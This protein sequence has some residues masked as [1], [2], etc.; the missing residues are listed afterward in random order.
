VFPLISA[1]LTLLLSPSTL[2]NGIRLVELPPGADTVEIV[3]GYTTGG[4]TGFASTPAAKALMLDAYA[5]GATIDFLNEIDRTA[6]RIRTAKWT[7]PMLTDRLASLF[8]EVPKGTEASDPSSRD[9]R[10]KVEDEIR[11]A[12]VGPRAP[13]V[14]YATDEAFVLISSPAP[15]SL[16]DALSAIPKRASANRAEEAIDRLPAERTFRFKSDIPEGAVIFASPVPSVYYKQWYLMLLLDR[17]IHHVVRLPLKT[18]LPLTVRPY[19]YRVE[20]PVPSGQLPEPAE[21]N[22]LQE[23]Q[24]LQFTAANARDLAAARQEALAYLDSNPVREWF[25]SQDIVS[26]REEGLQWL[27]SMSSD[28][29]RLAARD[30]LIMNRVLVTWS[31]RPK[32]IAVSSEPLTAV[33]PVGEAQARQRAASINDRPGRSQSAPIEKRTELPNERVPISF[34]AHNDRTFSTSL[35]E[36]LTSGVSIV[37]STANAVFVSG[38]PFTRFDHELIAEDL[39]PFQQYR[40]DRILVLSTASSMD[41]ARR[42]WSAFK[43]NANGETVLPKG[44][45]PSGNLSA[46]FVLKTI[47]DLKVI[48]SGWS[49]DALP[50]IDAGEGSNLQIPA[51]DEKRQQILDWIKAIANTPLADAYFTWAREV[52]MHH[53]ESVLPHLQALTWERDAQG[54]VQDPVTVSAKHVQ[55]VARIYF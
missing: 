37:T 13:R 48:E 24:R 11:N 6:V 4:L 15:D 47:L 43:G 14:D 8:K 41:R 40:A 25:A 16:R 19:Y 52:A 53:F 22:L 38:G 39:K 30:L 10:A 12:L 50:R 27:Q 49:G 29:M 17:L 42:I 45:V 7:V 44:S 18:T 35:P 5:A 31:P 36:R 3:A 55:D 46:L 33:G 32:Q 51:S 20:L 26:R 23:L 1:I 28:D 54:T 21:E 9:F 2:P 34:P